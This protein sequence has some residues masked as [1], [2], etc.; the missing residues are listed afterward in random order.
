VLEICEHDP[1]K[2]AHLQAQ[3]RQQ[4]QSAFHDGLAVTGFELD[5]ESGNYRMER[6]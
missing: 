3:I 6:M 5:D 1:A 4:F 2:A